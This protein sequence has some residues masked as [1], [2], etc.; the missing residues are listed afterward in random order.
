MNSRKFADSMMIFLKKYKTYE[1]KEELLVHYGLETIYIFITKMILITIFS[2]LI[3]LT[4]EMYIFIFF[5]GLLRLYASGMHLSSSIA[6]TI[7]STIILIGLPL[8]CLYTDIPFEYRFLINGIAIS[9]FALYSPA[10]TVKK[11]LIKEKH[12]IK[13]KFKS[14][15]VCFI[16]LGL[17]LIIKDYFILNCIT[18]ALILQ[19]FLISPISYK[20]FNQPY[21]NYLNYKDD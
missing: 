9:I 16:Y 5:Y 13:N 21:N 7:F 12:R 14:V 8:L 1:R 3:G 17:T 20:L 6:C 19:S 11:P 2:L 10:D 4:K 15:I 18:Y